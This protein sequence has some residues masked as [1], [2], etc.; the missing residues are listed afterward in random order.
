MPDAPKG[1]EC[2]RCRYYRNH[3]ED[4]E[5]DSYEYEGYCRRYPP[6]VPHEEYQCQYPEVNNDTWCGEYAPA[7]PDTFDDATITLA[8]FVLLGDRT[9]A[10]GLVDKLQESKS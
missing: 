7:N 10:M 9:A 4:E 6:S 3:S 1:Q 2:C 5:A 8:R